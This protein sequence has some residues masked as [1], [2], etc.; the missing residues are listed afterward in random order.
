MESLSL[1]NPL[2]WGLHFL[3]ILLWMF[4]G[5]SPM[6]LFVP[7]CLSIVLVIADLFASGSDREYI[8]FTVVN[9]ISNIIGGIIGII[10][11]YVH[12]PQGHAAIDAM[13]YA[14]VFVG[15]YFVFFGMAAM[16]GC[17]LKLTKFR[18]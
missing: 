9:V 4:A 12:G 2:Y 17:V 13:V 3:V 16:I 11:S 1:K 8:L 15:G 14:V 18:T 7:L 5:D 6:F 10:S